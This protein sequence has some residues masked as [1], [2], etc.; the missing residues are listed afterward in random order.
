MRAKLLFLFVSV[1]AFML[2]LPA[3]AVPVG[4]TNTDVIPVNCG[5]ED[6]FVIVNAGNSAWGADADGNP[7][8]TQYVLKEIEVRVYA[9]DLATE[10]ATDPLFVFSKTFGKKAGLGEALQCT[11]REVEVTPEG[12]VTVFGRAFVV[13]VR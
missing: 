13:Q 1:I 4:G 5:G 11:F 3:S 9:G 6:R 10:P 7:D 2:A 12:T 8:G